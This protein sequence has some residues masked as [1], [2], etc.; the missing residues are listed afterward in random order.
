MSELKDFFFEKTLKRLEKYVVEVAEWG[1]DDESLK[2]LSEDKIKHNLVRFISNIS[3]DDSVVNLTYN[4]KIINIVDAQESKSAKRIIKNFKR[5]A[6]ESN[7]PKLLRD[8]RRLE[9]KFE[10]FEDLNKENVSLSSEKVK[11]EKEL[12]KKNEQLSI[13][14]SIA[15]QDLI[16]VTNLHHQ[17]RVITD[18]IKT[19]L[20]LFSRKIEKN[21]KV[22]TLEIKEFIDKISFETSKIE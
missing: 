6:S 8:A 2:E 10:D 5:I 11:I 19:E 18:V 17:V 22:S 9:K 15:S 20:L 3:A 21:E 14:T 7:N 13:T 1:V 4:D 12:E 16:N